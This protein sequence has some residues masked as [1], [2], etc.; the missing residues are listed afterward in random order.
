[1]YASRG[2]QALAVASLIGA[3]LLARQAPRIE[4][5]AAQVEVD[6]VAMDDSGRPVDGLKQEEFQVREDGRPATVTSLISSAARSE[7]ADG[8][9][10]GSSVVLILD[11]SGVRPRLTNRVQQIA[12]QFVARAG[13]SD[14]LSV[15]RLN[16]RRDEPVGDR[17][18]ALMRIAEYRAGAMPFFGRD[19][20]E[21][22][23]T[24]V[25]TISG[26]FD[27]LDHKR[28]AIV[29]IGAPDVFDIDEPRDRQQ[30][31]IWKYW[32]GALA[33]AARVHV[34]VY[35]VDPNGLSSGGMLVDRNGIAA[36]TGGAAFYNRND[37]ASAV[38]QVWQDAGHYY[39]LGYTPAASKARELH[40][41]EV[42]VDR[43][44][45]KVRARRNRGD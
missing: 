30:S 19:T 40:D 45:V 38:R 12:K 33:A 11:D 27:Q 42:R 8:R 9:I 13:V 17:K 41:I 10:N 21:T 43:P 6:V 14:E 3:T 5:S 4:S 26:G 23:L 37:F 20:I 35:V 2:F 24:R 1:M 39:L 16:N 44:G 34:S 32:V 15:M 25:A 31:L 7:D 28:R 18:E 36:R 29:A 22:A